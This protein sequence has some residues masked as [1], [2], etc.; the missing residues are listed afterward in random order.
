LEQKFQNRNIILNINKYSAFSL[1]ELSIVLIIMGLLV[2]GI[3]GGA[4][5]IKNAKIKSLIDETY[6]IRTAYN[7]FYSKYGRVPGNKAGDPNTM[8]QIGDGNSITARELIDD[9]L[10]NNVPGDYQGNKTG[11]IMRS[12]K[13]RDVY[14][15]LS[16]YPND[17]SYTMTDLAGH[18]ILQVHTSIGNVR[19]F[20][21][22]D[23][24]NIDVKMDDGLPKS[25]GVRGG[26]GNFGNY[27]YTNTTNEY[28]Q[29]S[30]I[31]TDLAIKFD[32]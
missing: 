20:S 17:T 15:F 28:Y 22:I 24:K 29:S 25:G 4:S 32:F 5:L 30:E 23:A 16:S 7:I 27:I 3:T 9:G 14:Y 8:A 21:H 26:M 10:V 6:S 12:R 19:L 1:I 11:H 31:G 18:N 13:A 2:A